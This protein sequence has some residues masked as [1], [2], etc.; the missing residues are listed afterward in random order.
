MSAQSTSVT[1]MV[2]TALKPQLVLMVAKVYI[3]V[4]FPLTFLIALGS[5]ELDA[6]VGLPAFLPTPA[7]YG[8]AAASFVFGAV[9][10]IY[11]YEQLIHR[12]D[13]SPSPTAGRTQ[14]LVT[15]GIYAHCRNPSIWGKL[16]GVLAVGFALNSFSFCFIILPIIL[17]ISL[18][19]KVVRQEPQLI[20]IFGPEYE[21]YRKEVP[22][23]VPWKI[24]FRRN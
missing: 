7:N 5:L 11:T 15:T 13:G 24:F 2:Q 12:G 16:F 19:E 14:R 22:L 10:W 23:F 4:L 9:L 21:T 20:E 3:P 8:I 17:T 6:L 18:V 1:S